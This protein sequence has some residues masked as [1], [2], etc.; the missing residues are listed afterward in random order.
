MMKKLM[1]FVTLAVA[2]V[3]CAQAQVW[4]KVSNK[5]LA[6]K[7]VSHL[8]HRATINPG[9]NQGWWGYIDGSAE[10]GGVGV[11]KADTYHCAI[12]IPGNHE[13]AGGKTIQAIRFGLVSSNAKDAKVW[14][15]KDKPSAIN[16]EQCIQVVDVPQSELGKVN[17]D[18]A[19]NSPYAIPSEGVYVGY[20][21]T[22]TNVQYTADAYPVLIGETDAPNTL[23]LR[24]ENAVKTW[25][26]LNGEGFG[27]LFLQVLLEGDFADNMLIPSNFTT[28]YA[29]IGGVGTV[30]GLLNNQGITP[31]TSIDYT[32]TTDNV[33]GEEKH[34]NLESPIP[35]NSKGIAVIQLKGDDESGSK[36]KTLTVTKVNGNPNMATEKSTQFTL[37]SLPEIIDRNVVVEEYTGTGCGWCP[38]GLVGMDNLRNTFGDRFVGI[39]IHRY[40]S[41][42]AMYIASYAPVSFGGA[43]SC[44]IDRGA[45]MDP[46]YGSA[47]DI[48]DDFSAEMAIPAMGALEVS[49]TFDEAF[50][51]VNATANA[52][53]LFDG[54]YQVEL[55]LVADGLTGS[56]SGWNQSNFFYQYSSSDL[57]EDLAQFG[58]GGAYGTSSVKGWIFNDVAIASSYVNKKNQIPGQALTAGTTGA[59]TYTL[60]LPTKE[61]LKNALQKDQIYVVAILLDSNGN[62]VNAAKKKVGEYDPSG[63]SSVSSANATEAVRYT[64]DGR[65]ISAPQHG[66][67]IV[68]MSDGTVKKVMVK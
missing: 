32:I 4:Q 38:R 65:Q 52:K 51:K 19:L 24:T 43:P 37:V 58:N 66:L 18:V 54:S 11:S 67:N 15:A 26:D 31:V 36:V 33:E 29:K 61:A 57:P 46:Y 28:A 7:S 16:T 64:L 39:G 63:I 68:K 55:A 40:N 44:R 5:T 56:G 50:T 21:F 1:F 25:S 34:V 30:A 9:A 45:E 22:I 60:N 14:I 42:D 53:P 59:F 41:T 23:L 2:G 12:F 17:I 47:N 6:P 62:V 8:S 49:G 3:M 13:V 48:R 27:K 20:S 10:L 35:F